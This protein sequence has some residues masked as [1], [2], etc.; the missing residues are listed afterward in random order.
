MWE[1]KTDYRTGEKYYY[2]IL[3]SE[4]RSLAPD[5]RYGKEVILGM[6]GDFPIQSSSGGGTDTTY[7]SS[8][9]TRGDGSRQRQT[10]AYYTGEYQA[11]KSKQASSKK[12]HKRKKQK[13]YK[14]RYPDHDDGDDEESNYGDWIPQDSYSS[15]EEEDTD[16][17][18]GVRG[19]SRHRHK[20]KKSKKSKTKSSSKKEEE[21]SRK[22]KS[23]KKKS[24]RYQDDSSSSSSE[25]EPDDR[26]RSK[27][28]KSKTSRH[29]HQ[30]VREEKESNA[31]HME[32]VTSTVR[33]QLEAQK[34][35]IEARKQELQA[36]EQAIAKERQAMLEKRESEEKERQDRLALEEQARREQFEKEYA[37]RQAALEAETKRQVQQAQLEAQRIAR[38]AE[39]ARRQAHEEAEA[40]RQQAAAL[41]RERQV[42]AAQQ[43]EEV[44]RIRHQAEQQQ[45]L[46]ESQLLALME[47]QRKIQEELQRQDEAEG[48]VARSQSTIAPPQ[49]LP[50][51]GEDRDEDN[52]D[53]VDDDN[54]ESESSSEYSTDDDDDSSS[55]SS[56]DPSISEPAEMEE[57]M[58]L[59]EIVKSQP[60]T[61]RDKKRQLEKK[62]AAA[63]GSSTTAN[64]TTA[65]TLNMSARGETN[66]GSTLQAREP[67][68]YGNPQ[69]QERTIV[70]SPTRRSASPG[71]ASRSVSPGAGSRSVSPG[72]GNMGRTQSGRGLGPGQMARVQ[73]G[74]GLGPTQRSM[75]RPGL[76]DN[77]T[78]S[79]RGMNRAMSS[80]RGGMPRQAS[81]RPGPGPRGISRS[82]SAHAMKMSWA[83]SKNNASGL[84]NESYAMYDDE[85]YIDDNTLKRPPMVPQKSVKKAK[86]DDFERP[87]KLLVLIWLTMA[88]ELGFDLGTTIIAFRSLLEE[89]D[90]C[91]YEISLGPI[92]MT[93]TAPFFLLVAAELAMLIRAILLAL[94]PNMMNAPEDRFDNEGNIITRSTFMTLLCCCLRWKVQVI[95]K[96]LGLL[97]LLNPF[98]GCVIAWILLYQ[99]D[100]KEAFMVLGFEAGSLTL[101]YISVCLEG[102]ITNY[103]EFMIHGLIPLVPFTVSI[104]LTLFYLKQNG[105]CYLVNDAVFMFNGCEV[106][107]HGYP[108]VDGVCH[109]RNGTTYPFVQKN[110]LDLTKIRSLD[111]VLGKTYQV[112]YC[113][114]DNPEGPQDVNFCFFDYDNGKLEG[115][116]TNETQAPTPVPIISNN[117]CG[118]TVS[119]G[120]RSVQCN[121]YVWQPT[122]DDSMHCRTMGGPGDP[123]KLGIENDGK[124]EGR[125]KDPSSC[126]LEVGDGNYRAY[127]D[128]FF[129]W[130]EPPTYDKDY[131][132]AGNSWLAYSSSRFP[133]QVATMREGG[134]EVV[135]PSV[136]FASTSQVQDDFK[137]FFDSCQPNCV[138]VGDISYV[139]ILAM[140]VYC[141]PDEELCATKVDEAVEAAKTVSEQFDNR[142]VYVTSFGVLNT[143]LPSKLSRAMVAT[144]NF[145]SNGSP[146]KR[147][148]WYGGSQPDATNLSFQAAEGAESSLGNVWARTCR[149]LN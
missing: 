128:A 96:F 5:D 11:T 68:P 15:S 34:Q 30:H 90:C 26:R 76:V 99:S 130:D 46:H 37:Q 2:N 63:T 143:Q 69:A 81:A 103:W 139:D 14:S 119:P 135:S 10:Y 94:F 44:A 121:R 28:G 70:A 136:I 83:N 8:T 74:R 118:A 51:A 100:K 75:P 149:D 123:C 146:V 35:E 98:F 73:S 132:W 142:P 31:A 91:G 101:H 122:E 18:R 7:A 64:N 12:Q 4:R 97:M 80:G 19:K 133:D 22:K 25:P 126:G 107:D 6:K 87:A 27:S 112:S 131:V 134:V 78:P 62:F 54:E 58:D 55:S 42:Q 65:S 61:A 85:E 66:N 125:F 16:D 41:E 60:P 67:Q 21:S 45:K 82:G 148:Y 116:V 23:K 144:S 138:T 109:F 113:A 88:G 49:R 36:K 20:E 43:A 13:K 47:E 114:E 93:V 71:P 105:V 147:V 129:L 102:A 17:K 72:P 145:F 40:V 59:N 120:A 141:D 84:G 57:S 9:Q 140:S 3:T 124:N 92:P 53:D 110:A 137:T 111:D 38:E 79:G 1:E 32:A 115:T 48:K 56:E 108:P 50:G 127:G 39:E 24:K 29:H 106:C 33:S 86:K 77:R 104:G 52:D 89:D 117:K 95:M